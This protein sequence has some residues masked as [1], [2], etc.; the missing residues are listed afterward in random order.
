M[1]TKI[2]L[3]KNIKAPIK[4]GQV[5]GSVDVNYEGEDYKIDLL[6]KDDVEEAS[7]FGKITRNVK[8]NVNFLLQLLIAR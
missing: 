6:S 8:N 7:T 2:N 3:D 4:K 5:L 1:A